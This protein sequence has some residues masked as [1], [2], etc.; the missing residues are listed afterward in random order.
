MEVTMPRTAVFALFSL[1]CACTGAVPAPET[2]A[3][4][5]S[6]P[7]D[8]AA[9]TGTSDA[10]SQPPIVRLADLPEGGESEDHAPIRIDVEGGTCEIL[11]NGR[12]LGASAPRRVRL[13]HGVH[14]L[15]CR[16]P[17]GTG[18]T[19]RV[20]VTASGPSRVTFKLL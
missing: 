7:S 8:V 19:Q 13:P 16:R 5:W 18:P 3:Q 1:M 6:M 17:D 10:V 11:V 2:P 9:Q 15:K 4:D 14:V 20:N 12:A